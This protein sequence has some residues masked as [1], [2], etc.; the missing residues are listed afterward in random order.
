M[1]PYLK[2]KDF[3][4]ARNGKGGLVLIVNANNGAFQP[5]KIIVKDQRN[6]WYPRFYPRQQIK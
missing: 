3:L 1:S 2:M 5:E 6:I 4:V